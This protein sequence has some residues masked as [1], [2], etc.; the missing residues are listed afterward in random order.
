VEFIPRPGDAGFSPQGAFAQKFFFLNVLPLS[1]VIDRVV[2]QK[3]NRKNGESV[4]IE[5][6]QAE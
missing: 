5:T 3:K 4:E 2:L 1:S 6:M